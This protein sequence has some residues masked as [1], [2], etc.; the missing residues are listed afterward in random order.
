MRSKNKRLKLATSN[1]SAA[2]VTQIALRLVKTKRY[3]KQ[4]TY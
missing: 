1:G 4:I 3:E 2:Q